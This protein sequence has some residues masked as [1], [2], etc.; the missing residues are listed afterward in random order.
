MVAIL[1]TFGAYRMQIFMLNPADTR[2][3]NEVSYLRF[4][5]IYFNAHTR[6]MPSDSEQSCFIHP[7]HFSYVVPDLS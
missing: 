6:K 5:E 7:E 4:V 1:T 3:E 2:L